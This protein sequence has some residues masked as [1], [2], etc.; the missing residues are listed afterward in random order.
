MDR[1]P[2]TVKSVAPARATVRTTPPAVRAAQSSGVDAMAF[3]EL[4]RQVTQLQ[5]TVDG[6]EKERDFYFGK[7]RDIEVAVQSRLGALC[8]VDC[9]AWISCC[10][11]SVKMRFY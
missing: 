3:Q 4:N 1:A 9:C 6:L 10:C 7:L 5:V 8:I 2:K 11:L